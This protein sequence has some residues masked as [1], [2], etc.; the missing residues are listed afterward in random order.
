M[1]L[2]IF[3]N[4]NNEIKKLRTQTFVVEKNVPQEI[5]F[6]GKDADY[7]H[8]C[9][10]DGDMLIACARINAEAN[11]LHAGRVAVKSELRG[12]GYGRL[13]FEYIE[14]YA[15]ENGFKAIEL[16]AIETAVEF[17]KKVGFETV[18]EYFTEAGWPHINMVKKIAL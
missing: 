17:Y 15:K 12:K 3:N 9:L 8:F 18:G 6:D 10:Y 1:E 11:H 5:E 14:K 2:K 7:M 4:S 13:L 16:G